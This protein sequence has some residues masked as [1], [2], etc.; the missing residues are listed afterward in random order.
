M[1]R[2]TQ[3]LIASLIFTGLATSFA[4]ALLNAED[5]KKPKELAP[6]AKLLKDTDAVTKQ[7]DQICDQEFGKPTFRDIVNYF[8]NIHGIRVRIDFGMYKRCR[9]D[10]FAGLEED[11]TDPE[12]SQLSIQKTRSLTLRQLLTET[13]N[14][15]HGH[16]TFVVREGFVMIVPAFLPQMIPGSVADEPFPQRVE[17][18]EIIEQ[19]YG[20]PI[21]LNAAELS[22]DDLI[23]SLR[24]KSGANILFVHSAFPSATDTKKLKVSLEVENVRLLTALK[25]ICQSI[26]DSQFVLVDNVYIVTTTAKA[27]IL[28][29]QV[30]RELFG[31]R[32]T[33]VPPGQVFDGVFYYE[34]PQNL[35]PIMPPFF[36][37]CG[38]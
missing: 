32:E 26:P 19:M 15:L 29:K 38:F 11:K 30:N 22:I 13:M 3:L 10:V 35:K 34:K 12:K 37:I 6:L 8:E 17:R 5:P 4:F 7:L 18:S 20:Q 23:K 31:E 28:Q 14:Q 9:R 36:G 2:L 25:M 24:S 33:I 21:S 16:H 27:A 1:T